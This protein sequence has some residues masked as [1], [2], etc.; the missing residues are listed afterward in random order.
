M[1]SRGEE[2]ATIFDPCKKDYEVHIPHPFRHL[3]PFVRPLNR[4]NVYI[5]RAAEM[6]VCCFLDVDFTIHY[7][8]TPNVKQI[9]M[10]PSE[11]TVK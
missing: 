2:R 3:V 4:I 10:V 8:L 9:T 7:V 6:H 1:T 5:I 11:K